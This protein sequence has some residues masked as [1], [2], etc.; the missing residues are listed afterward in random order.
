M[1][2]G[3]LNAMAQQNNI[4][5][6]KAFF[7]FDKHQYANA[8]AYLDSSGI[9]DE[10]TLALKGKCLMSQSHFDKAI[11]CLHKA[12]EHQAHFADYELALCYAQH[13]QY[14]STAY[15]LKSNL[16]SIY[17]KKSHL[18]KFDTLL[19]SFRETSLWKELKVSHPYSESE[20]SLEQAIYYSNHN[21]VDLALDILDELIRNDKKNSEYYY[22]RAKYILQFNKDYQYAIGDIKKAI[23]YDNDNAEYY[24][25]L[26]DC[27]LNT[28]RYKKANKAY[29][30]AFKLSS[31]AY[32]L[33][34]KLS[35][36]FFRIGQY[37]EAEKYIQSYINID[38]QNVD[39]LKLIALIL[40]ETE[41]Y[42][43]S[44]DYLYKACS[45][46]ARRADLLIARGK[47]FM[48]MENYQ[49]ALW[50]FGT[51]T[52][53]DARNGEFWFYKGLAFLFDKRNKEACKCFTRAQN[54]NYYQAGEYLLKECQ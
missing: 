4:Y 1:C 33:M 14:D 44:L 37:A 16:E 52:D 50:D 11:P 38:A 35:F 8:L 53:L 51:A 9:K 29:M 25:F 22:Y 42:Q 2:V 54:L 28:T 26:G 41:K 19:N 18:L 39:A 17:K 10:Y 34:Y 49:N 7:Y 45:I 40:Y 3:F 48:A 23:K 13:Q 47:V 43:A 12:N 6:N 32:P 20:K 24:H 30:S 36:S 15:F 31:Y 5:V 27:Y 46:D 21:E